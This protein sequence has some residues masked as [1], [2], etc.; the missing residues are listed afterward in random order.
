MNRGREF[1]KI[2]LGALVLLIGYAAL[3][4]AQGPPWATVIRTASLAAGGWLVLSGLWRLSSGPPRCNWKDCSQRRVYDVRGYNP[5][6]DSHEAGFCN[7]HAAAILRN[8]PEAR[9]R[10]AESGKDVDRST[11]LSGFE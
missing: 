6:E 11:V 4:A 8:L 9:A 5:E 1:G 7:L 2:G 10:S 3:E